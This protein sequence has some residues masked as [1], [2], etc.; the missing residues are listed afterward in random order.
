M[1]TFNKYVWESFHIRAARAK[2]Q[3]F[4]V[5]RCAVGHGRNS[6]G[7]APSGQPGIPREVIRKSARSFSKIVLMK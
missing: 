6:K 2:K 1:K 4:P 3:F 7:T 5:M